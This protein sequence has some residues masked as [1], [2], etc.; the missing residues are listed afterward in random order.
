[1]FDVMI[2]F[3]RSYHK[4]FWGRR[5]A[6]K[7]EGAISPVSFCD[8]AFSFLWVFFGEGRKI[9]AVYVEN[10]SENLDGTV[11]IY[12][13]FLHFKDRPFTNLPFPCKPAA[14][15]EN[16]ATDHPRRTT[17]VTGSTPSARKLDLH[18]VPGHQVPFQRIF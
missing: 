3:H 6:G 4:F 13:C 12:Y 9:L 11:P 14:G 7:L 18:I 10:I 5:D 1:M 15:R 17:P 2:P 8:D 16:R